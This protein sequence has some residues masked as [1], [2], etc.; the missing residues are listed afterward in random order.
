MLLKYAGTRMRMGPYTC[1]RAFQT[2]AVALIC[3]SCLSWRA[4]CRSLVSDGSHPSA[5]AHFGAYNDRSL[6]NKCVATVCCRQNEELIAE[7][8]Q[9]RAGSKP[10]AFKHAYPQSFGRQLQLLLTRFS[11]TY[12][13]SPFY[14][15]VRFTFTIALGLIIGAMYWRLGSRR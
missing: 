4:Q 11:L 7:L 6:E 5:A 3:L 1:R 2:C 14:N 9:P 12:W 13:R 10:L 8:S 15:T